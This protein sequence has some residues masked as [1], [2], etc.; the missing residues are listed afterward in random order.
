M[1][2]ADLSGFCILVLNQWCVR[3]ATFHKDYRSEKTQQS[4]Q[5]TIHK[6]DRTSRTRWRTAS[7]AEGAESGRTGTANPRIFIETSKPSGD[8]AGSDA[9]KETILNR[10]MDNWLISQQQYRRSPA[11]CSTERTQTGLL[12]WPINW[13][14]AVVE[15]WKASSHLRMKKL[16]QWDKFS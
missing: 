7:D 16:R 6:S 10:Q 3:L 4:R 12:C 8:N 14:Q 13:L 15:S 9:M 11:S 5:V 2:N 1:A